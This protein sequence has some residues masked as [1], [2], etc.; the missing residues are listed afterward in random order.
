MKHISIVKKL[1]YV[2]VNSLTDSGIKSVIDTHNIT[3][4]ANERDAAYDNQAMIQA[5]VQSTGLTYTNTQKALAE[6]KSDRI[7]P[8]I[9]NI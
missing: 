2:D 4:A 9:I 7:T 5:A 6:A 1:L 8:M 3:P